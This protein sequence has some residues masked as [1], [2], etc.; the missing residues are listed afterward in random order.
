M[1]DKERTEYAKQFANTNRKFGKTHF[2]KVKRQLDKVVS[3]LIGTIKKRGPRQALVDL[4][5]MLWNDELYKPIEAI[6]KS[7]GVYWANQTYK[8][9]RR[10][11]GQKGIGRSEEWAKFVMDELE[12][13]LLQYAVVKTSETLRNHLILVLQSSIAK[14]LTVDEI[15]K[16]FQES[17]FTAMQAERIIRTEVGRAANTGVKASAES[18]NYEMVKEWIAFRDTRTRGFKPEQPKDHYHMDGQVVDFYDNFVDPRS[19]EQIEYP[20]AP[21]GSAG[22]VINCRCSWI[23]VPKR[24]SR[25]RLI[26]RGGA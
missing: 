21:G 5:T 15:V 22:M 20:L 19:K 7:V 26:N 23:V 16:L 17:G 13:T 3:S 14:E 1:T 2:P 11:A 10:E 18:F 8:L 6:Y 9:I 25:G 12:R 4:R 24:D